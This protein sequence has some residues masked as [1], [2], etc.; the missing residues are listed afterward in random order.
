VLALLFQVG[1]LVDRAPTEQTT[2]T[3]K[4]LLATPASPSAV[5]ASPWRSSEVPPWPG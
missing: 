1:R 2:G 4:A 3:M 5:A